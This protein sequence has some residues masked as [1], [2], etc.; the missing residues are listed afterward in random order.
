MTR[1]ILIGY[2]GAG[3]TTLGRVLA[4]KLQVEFFDLDWYI[5]NR[6]R[7]KIPQIFAEELLPPELAPA[8]GEAPVPADERLG[9]AAMVPEG[10]PVGVGD[11]PGSVDFADVEFGPDQFGDAKRMHVVEEVAPH[12][13]VA[14]PLVDVEP[15]AAGDE[16][17]R[18]V[19]VKVEEALEERLPAD[20]LVDLVENENRLSLAGH[21]QAGGV[22][23]PGRV[24]P[25]LRN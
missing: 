18:P 7:M 21:V 1:I 13:A 10:V 12:E 9:E 24:R 20:E 23:E 3:K 25:D 6:F 19:L 11:G 5:E 17:A 14:A 15:R 2:M 4:R 16:D 22:G 8:D